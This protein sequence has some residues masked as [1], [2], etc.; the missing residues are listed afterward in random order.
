MP[1][2]FANT[3]LVMADNVLTI[4]GRSSSSTRCGTGS[5]VVSGRGRYR[6]PGPSRGRSQ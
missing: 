2:V 4:G 6:G 5:V 3:R 1:D